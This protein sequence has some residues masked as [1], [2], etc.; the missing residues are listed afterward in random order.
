M[1]KTDA[2]KLS[3]NVGGAVTGAAAAVAPPAA[4][5]SPVA[6]T[7]TDNPLD[8]PL[9]PKAGATL[10]KIDA[11]IKYTPTLSCSVYKHTSMQYIIYSI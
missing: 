10:A 1:L 5:V 11:C 6:G 4:A 3:S 2:Q 8:S 7:T 9:A